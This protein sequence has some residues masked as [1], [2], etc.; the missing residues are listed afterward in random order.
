MC[1]LYLVGVLSG[2]VISF[3]KRDGYLRVDMSNPEK[4]SYLLDIQTD[5]DKINKK[6]R[7]I[8]K[9]DTKYI[10]PQ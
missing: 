5:L 3:V 8:L 4:D 9:I 2:V 10:K 1:L 6:K 7:L